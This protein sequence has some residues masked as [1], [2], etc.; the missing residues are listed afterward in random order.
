[1]SNAI[2][3]HAKQESKQACSLFLITELE[4]PVGGL[5]R[6]ASELL[7]CWRESFRQ[8]KTE[9]E[10]VVLAMH[11]PSLPLSDLVV[12]RKFDELSAQYPQ[13][14][15]Y[16]AQRGGE[17]CY[18]L[19]AKMSQ[20]EGND[21][22]G[23]IYF[24]YRI[25]SERASADAYYRTLCAYWKYAPVAAEFLQRKLGMQIHVIDAQD[26][27]AFPAGFGCSE[28]LGKPLLCRYHSGEYGRSLGNPEE[29]SA[30]L[31]IE[32]AGLAFA[33]FVQG[34]SIS[35]AKFELLNLLEAKR[36]ICLEVAPQMPSG[37]LELQARKDQK[38]EEF[39]LLESDGL[40]LVG[41]NI[42]GIPN[43]IL[44][45]QWK[46]MHIADIYKG[47]DML[48]SIFEKS[49]YVL[50]IGRTERRKGINEL[51]VAMSLL[52]DRNIGLVVASSMSP[53]ERLA[54]DET[55]SK[56]GLGRSVAIY[57]GWLSDNAKRSLLCAADVVALPSL[58]EPFGLVTLEALAADLACESN[59]IRGPVV[60]VGANGGMN[61]VI[62]NGVNGFKAPMKSQFELR[63]DHLAAIIS[64]ACA[65]D[66][67]LRARISK[68]AAQ[69]VQSPYFD[70]HFTVLRIHECY[71]RACKNHS[72]SKLM[73]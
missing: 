28:K 37:W 27:L 36:K 6:F 1:M 45:E 59:G 7:S 71:R 47:R 14:K 24:K 20:Q 50:F 21:F 11:D 9:F 72:A 34:V 66:G 25:R 12:S 10:P 13:L 15:V 62:R 44:L 19:E 65:E 58:Y 51:L 32:A 30:P 29:G 40:D 70:W 39:L 17:T 41:D 60:I 61:E 22:L 2:E 53:A 68:G 35:E 49:S 55:I 69:R 3:K 5:S 63:S 31:C 46:S 67:Q 52:K 23:Q 54:L 42:A 4:R 57:D 64:M 43:G 38:Y 73:I 33:D 26:W 16:E 18:F 56:M 48:K 8:G